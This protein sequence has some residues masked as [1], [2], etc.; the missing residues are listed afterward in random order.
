MMGTVRLQ[1]CSKVTDMIDEKLKA[2]IERALS[3]GARV[4]LKLM[5]DGM[6]KAQVIKAEE[7]KK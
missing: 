2:A 6:V 3:S 4:Q 1:D 7:L 5:K